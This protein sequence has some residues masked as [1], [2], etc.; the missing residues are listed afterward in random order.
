MLDR[1][2]ASRRRRRGGVLQR[3][4]RLDVR[5]PD[6]RRGALLR[7][8]AGRPRRGRVRRGR[9]VGLADVR[10][11]GGRR[12]GRGAGPRG[13]RERDARAAGRDGPRPDR[14][15]RRPRGRRL[16]GLAA[17]P[18][19]RARRR[20]RAGQLELEQPARARPRR[21]GALLRRRVRLGGHD[22][23]ARPRHGVDHVPPPRLRRLPRGAR[24]GPA[25]A[26]RRPVGAAGLQRRGG[27]G[28]AARRRRAAAL[29]RDVLRRRH[30]RSRRARGRAGR[31]DPPRAV[32]RRPGA[33]GHAA[34]PAGRRV[35]REH[36][37]AGRR[38]AERGGIGRCGQRREPAWIGGG[39]DVDP[40]L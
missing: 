1:R 21:G 33:D 11:G 3:P 30:G 40:P 24:P 28:R 18:A 5:G 13:G 7:R 38:R 17:R 12:R 22:D 4:A 6:A 34:R 27:L 8:A 32:R 19:C 2:D 20:Q 29:A 35:Q 9:V 25:R 36:V 31:R 15:L 26:P 23:R 10:V 14:G 37:R 39:P 16:R